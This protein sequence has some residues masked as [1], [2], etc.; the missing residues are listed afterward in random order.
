MSRYTVSIGSLPKYSGNTDQIRTM[1]LPI[2]YSDNQASLD[3]DTFRVSVDDI[4]RMLTDNT[5]V[6]T[7]DRRG[8]VQLGSLEEKIIK[9]NSSG[10]TTVSWQLVNPRNDEVAV[11]ASRYD[12][13]QALGRCLRHGDDIDGGNVHL[14]LKEFLGVT[15]AASYLEQREF[16]VALVENDHGE[17]VS[18]DLIYRLSGDDAE[19]HARLVTFPSG[20]SLGNIT[21]KVKSLETS[22]EE[23]KGVVE[24]KL[25]KSGGELSGTLTF[26]IPSSSAT[27]SPVYTNKDFTAVNT[28]DS[29]PSSGLQIKR[30][31]RSG[32]WTLSIDNIV[33]R[34]N[35]YV[36]TL[37]IDE[38][39]S[40]SGSL[41]ISPGHGKITTVVDNTDYYTCYLDQ[42]ITINEAG[43][44]VVTN[45]TSIS[46]DEGDY[47][48]CSKYT[49]K[50]IKS[51]WLPTTSV[52]KS[53][54]SFT[55]SKSVITTS[56]PEVGDEIVTFGNIN[57][58]SRQSLIMITGSETNSPLIATYD[59]LNQNNPTALAR[60][61][62]NANGNIEG[63]QTTDFGTLH[64][65]GFYSRGNTYISG[66]LRVVSGDGKTVTPVPCYKGQFDLTATYYVGDEVTIDNETWRFLGDAS[67]EYVTGEVPSE[68]K[69]LKVLTQGIQGESS[70]S[71]SLYSSNGSIFKN[72]QVTTTLSAVVKYGSKDITGI[73]DPSEFRWS[74]VSGDPKYQVDDDDW[75]YSN[76][77][78]REYR[79][80]GPTLEVTP[81]DISHK[82]SFDCEVFDDY[83]ITN[84]AKI[85]LRKFAQI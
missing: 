5:N 16:G 17:V 7:K 35:M 30:D 29:T 11:V 15:N 43:E 78:T 80:T 4:L 25:D 37:V 53:T 8:V 54:G 66:H 52:D 49:G 26:N 41:V 77:V 83:S 55:I 76:K 20:T 70:Y 10:D 23:L 12:L 22:V 61:L 71:V 59:G 46:I 27:G 85:A 62:I 63:I 47:V 58:P 1:F 60:C 3:T 18:A 33:V 84:E 34:D 40:V 19:G 31:G 74:R 13:V 73:F 32:L 67:T 28:S 75:T 69:W 21:E 56:G 82:A 6:A 14:L 39:R 24:H 42:E 36:P 50:N 79:H 64:G 9:T 57:N 51:Y 72:G 81:S 2:G 68:G 65:V 45:S 48:R 38:T 44:K